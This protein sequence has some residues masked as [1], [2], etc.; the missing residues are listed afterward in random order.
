MPR[1][2][3]KAVLDGLDA[4]NP[5]DATMQSSLS[6]RPLQ[7]SSFFHVAIVTL[8]PILSITHLG[9]STVSGWIACLMGGLASD[10]FG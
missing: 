1:K 2:Q 5:H 3:C 8:H 6:I 7:L 4:L 10:Y 9:T